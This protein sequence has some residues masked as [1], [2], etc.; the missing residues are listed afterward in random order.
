MG[1][2]NCGEDSKGRPI[3][4]CHA[5]T[6]DH[7]GCTKQIDRGLGY[8]C[9]GMHGT[10]VGCEGYFCGDHM[11]YRNDPGEG[12]GVQVCFECAEALDEEQK[13]DYVGAMTSFVEE[14]AEALADGYSAEAVVEMV[15]AKANE[16]GQHFVNWDDDDALQDLPPGADFYDDATRAAVR[17]ARGYLDAT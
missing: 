14:L 7:E 4:Y 1:W 11:V 15:K 13:R 5:A 10:S 12:R 9:G 3:G 8:A 6:C 17:R 16:F 2:G